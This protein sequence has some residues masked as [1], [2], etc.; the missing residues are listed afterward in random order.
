MILYYY[1]DREVDPSGSRRPRKGDRVFDFGS[2]RVLLTANTPLTLSDGQIRLLRKDSLFRHLEE[3]S[4]VEIV[5]EE[6]TISIDSLTATKAIDL[7]ESTDDL[8]QVEKFLE[9]ETARAKPRSVVMSAIEKRKAELNAPIDTSA[10]NA[11][12]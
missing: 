1:P 11:N 2:E 4:A 5:G 10:L 6:K 12:S 9:Q 3:T 7:I 8:K